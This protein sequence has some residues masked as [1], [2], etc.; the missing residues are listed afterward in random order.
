MVHSTVLCLTIKMYALTKCVTLS[1]TMKLRCTLLLLEIFLCLAALPLSRAL[2]NDTTIHPDDSAEDREFCFKPECIHTASRV[3]RYMDTNFDPCDNFYKFA[4]GKLINNNLIHGDNSVDEFSLITKIIR[5][6]MT[7]YLQ[8]ETLP[9]TLPRYA[10]LIKTFYN[11]CTDKYSKNFRKTNLTSIME[12]INKTNGWPLLEGDSWREEN[13]QWEK[14]G[15]STEN[16]TVLDN[17]FIRLS[18][19]VDDKNNSYR[20]LL[21]NQ[22]QK[23]ITSRKLY[24]KLLTFGQL[25]GVKRKDVANNLKQISEVDNQLYS[26]YVPNKNKD[27]F[28]ERM[29]VK[30]LI[31]KYP[32]ILWR[33]FFNTEIKPHQIDDDDVILVDHIRYFDNFTQLI[34]N[35]SK[36]DQAN[37][38][39]WRA[40]YRISAS[41][42]NAIHTEYDSQEI[43]YDITVGN[44]KNVF[45]LLYSKINFNK[46]SFPKDVDEMFDNIY[47]EYRTILKNNSWLDNETK[48][49][50]L[51]KLES[52]IIVPPTQYLSH[53]D[54]EID[55]YY[56]NLEIT[57]GDYFRSLVNILKFYAYKY[58][59]DLDY[60]V[61]KTS[62]TEIPCASDVNAF[63][64]V[65]KN[66][67]AFMP[68]IFQGV[69]FDKERPQYMNYGSIGSTIGHEIT[70]SFDSRGRKYDKTGNFFNWWT[71][72]ANESFLSKV[73]C[74]I[75]Q[76]NNYRV[77]EVGLNIKGNETQSEDTSDIV[78]I[79]V[80]YSAY[81]NYMKT[82]GPEP[83]LPGVNYT[84]RQ[85]FWIS[86]THTHIVQ[87]RQRKN[88]SGLLI[89]VRT[90]LPNFELS[91][92]FPIVWNSQKISNVRQARK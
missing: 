52:M 16:I 77:E 4:C 21:I 92:P 11:S 86:Y 1:K 48:L 13:F 63:N 20:R 69:F 78:G 82:Y 6:K 72:E 90:V 80:A 91:V 60:P 73:Q 2:N 71:A 37:Y 67:I 5:E 53:D 3:L 12:L 15:F 39:M 7:V 34:R 87:Q 10:R 57:P 70:H 74:I 30:E 43:C 54:K 64:N 26:I 59:V 83:L 68:A 88:L 44:F 31:R 24:N 66:L 33:N 76:H 32:N 61:N 36:R 84:Q 8:N 46:D 65:N 62:W 45:G 29:T 81:E 89:T 55:E 50:A 38:L 18:I 28:F 40:I 19:I 23:F 27:D 22:P 9:N 49:K 56:K 85:L 41:Y 58:F 79:N 42:V 14:F 75:D 47:N 25:F 35:I 51:E 17:N